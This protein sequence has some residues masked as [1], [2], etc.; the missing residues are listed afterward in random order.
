VY[1]DIK[2]LPEA[3][4]RRRDKSPPFQPSMK[5]GGIL[6]R[7]LRLWHAG[8][9][10]QTEQ[11]RPMIAMI[12]YARWMQTDPPLKFPKERKRFSPTAA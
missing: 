12:H 2:V 11:P 9:P 7:D 4:E 3:L 6:I 1:D 10:N 8:M 5:R